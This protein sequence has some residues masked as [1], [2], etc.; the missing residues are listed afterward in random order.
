MSL[1]VVLLIES[2]CANPQACS[3]YYVQCYDKSWHKD[4]LLSKNERD[5]LC[6]T[7][8]LEALNVDYKLELE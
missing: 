2:L 8:L 7:E 1:I 6:A 4:V 3:D 5:R